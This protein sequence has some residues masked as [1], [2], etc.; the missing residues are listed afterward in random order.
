MKVEV[1]NKDVTKRRLRFMDDSI[2]YETVLLRGDCNVPLVNGNIADDSR[3]VALIPTIRNLLENKNKV[4]LTSHLGR[5]TKYDQAFSM[6][7]VANHIAGLMPDVNIIFCA[8]E[9]PY[10]LCSI[11]SD[12][13]F[14]RSVLVTENLRFYK[15]ETMNDPQFAQSLAMMGTVFVNDAFGCLHREHASIVGVTS[16]LPSYAGLL[17]KKEMQEIDIITSGNHRPAVAIIGGSK[18]S[19]KAPIIKNL[20]NVMDKIILGGGV[21]NYLLKQ[22]GYEIGLSLV[23]DICDHELDDCVKENVHKI[24]VPHTVVVTKNFQGNVISFSEVSV[25]NVA[26]DDYIVDVGSLATASVIAMLHDAKLAVW[27]GPMGLFEKKPFDQSS[28]TIGRELA[29]LTTK[30]QIHSIVGGGDVVSLISANGLAKSFSHVSTGGGS[31]LA[32]LGG[33]DLPGLKVLGEAI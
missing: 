13:E 11:V 31:L 20:V 17:I 16:F 15:G 1:M 22:M 27:N 30:G 14:G 6:Y 28:V 29:G 19:T 33:Q 2:R 26:S 7:G 3:L 21:A 25:D 18:I 12:M 32:I 5:P 10:T 24:S 23:E 4:V 9:E 8:D